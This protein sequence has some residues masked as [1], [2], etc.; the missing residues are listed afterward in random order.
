MSPLLSPASEESITA[1]SI[2]TRIRALVLERPRPGSCWVHQAD[3]RDLDGR[4]CFRS[5]RAKFNH[6]IPGDVPSHRASR[7]QRRCASPAKREARAEIEPCQRAGPF[8]LQNKIRDSSSAVAA[9]PR[10]VSSLT[11]TAGESRAVLFSNRW[12]DWGCLERAKQSS[13]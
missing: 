9:L 10:N 2:G 12:P 13:S 1:E 6:A 5:L 3:G 4:H 7:R 11:W 8:D